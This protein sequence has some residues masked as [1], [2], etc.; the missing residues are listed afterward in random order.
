VEGRTKLPRVA[1]FIAD[2]KLAIGAD[3]LKR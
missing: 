2:V 1:E 3:V